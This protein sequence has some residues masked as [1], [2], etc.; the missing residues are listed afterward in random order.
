M[1]NIIRSISKKIHKN[2]V[3]IAM[4]GLDNAGKTCILYKLLGFNI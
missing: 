1:G 2:P 3:K 4:V